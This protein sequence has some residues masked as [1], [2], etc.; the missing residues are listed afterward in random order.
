MAQKH[1]TGDDQISKNNDST[2]IKINSKETKQEVIVPQFATE[3]NLQVLLKENRAVIIHYGFAPVYNP[4]LE[5]K[6][7]VKIV[8][9]G[10]VVMPQSTKAVAN[11]N[12]LISG[13]LTKNFGEIWKKDLGFSPFGTE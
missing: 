2:T 4:E 1:K 6:Y 3:E 7:G 11:N 9:E 10:C 5:K 12:R 8:N 13:F